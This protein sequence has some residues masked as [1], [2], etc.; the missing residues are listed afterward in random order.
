[1]IVQPSSSCQI[2]F[3]D[4]ASCPVSRKSDDFALYSQQLATTHNLSHVIFL[5]QTHS[6]QGTVITRTT[7]PKQP[8]T[9][10]QA[11]G[12]YIITNQPH[13]GIGTLTADCLP[14]VFYAPKHN[15]IAVAHAGWKGS[16][17][18]IA[19][20]IV[21]QLQNEHGIQPSE[22]HVYFGPAAKPCCYEVQDD[23]LAQLEPFACKGQLVTTRD[24]KKF[25]DNA[26]LNKQLLM[27]AGVPPSNIITE[28]NICTIC[29]PQ[30]H[31]YRRAKH[32]DFCQTTMV[33]LKD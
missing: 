25:F 5:N 24:N 4:A 3:G 18:G 13:V 27:G 22:V 28:H 23:F 14:I 30:Y 11:E 6:T 31:S 8:V 7:L 21:M 19:P 33:W 26:L 16:V 10:F 12:D 20:K 29:N 1:M 9:L 2:F 32:S 17:A 15:T